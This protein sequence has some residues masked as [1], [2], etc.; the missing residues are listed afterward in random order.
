MRA[1][2]CTLQ[3]T[4]NPLCNVPLRLFLSPSPLCA[5]PCKHSELVTKINT[6]WHKNLSY[7]HGSVL[8]WAE[9]QRLGPANAPCSESKK[10][11]RFYTWCCHFQNNCCSNN[12][13][14]ICKTDP[15]SFGMLGLC[16]LGGIIPVLMTK[17]HLQKS[18]LFSLY[19]YELLCKWN[20]DVLGL[21]RPT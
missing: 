13:F 10:Y 17:K 4:T 12:S 15:N 18:V 16:F 9:P 5:A 20:R 6:S 14:S 3:N 21:N 2:F 19:L 7:T 8:N 11:N 1:V